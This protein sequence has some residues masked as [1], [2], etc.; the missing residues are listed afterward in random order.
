MSSMAPIKYV[1]ASSALVD[2][3][4][5]LRWC[6]D[7]S[8]RTLILK[9]TT[10]P[11][12]LF[13]AWINLFFEWN[14]LVWWMFTYLRWWFDLCILVELLNKQ[15]SNFLI[16]YVLCIWCL[17]KVYIS[18]ITELLKD[19]M[20]VV[21]YLCNPFWVM[22]FSTISSNVSFVWG[23]ILMFLARPAWLTKWYHQAHFIN[24]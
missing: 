6:C 18:L 23:C 13:G 5:H 20:R 24:I 12:F 19:P 3:L 11:V 15:E 1:M 10:I 8:Y 4:L 21:D 22:A 2:V 17:F 16:A 7:L 14:C 9:H